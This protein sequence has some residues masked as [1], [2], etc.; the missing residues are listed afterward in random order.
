M[1]PLTILTL[2]VGTAIAKAIVTD[3]LNDQSF[4]S[5]IASDFLDL[6]RD[7]V[8]SETERQYTT[9]QIEKIGQQIAVQMRP[10]FEQEVA[11]RSHLNPEAVIR[12]AVTTFQQAKIT[13]DLIVQKRVSPQRLAEYLVESR[14]EVL[15]SFSAD[16]THIYKYALTHLLGKVA[17]GR[18]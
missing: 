11:S 3:W 14:I 1:E 13:A 17:E 9:E 8:K 18:I 12:E 2:T 7:T 15:K 4:L 16:E 5:Q 10:R 6:L